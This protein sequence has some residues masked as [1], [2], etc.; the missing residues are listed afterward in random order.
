MFRG[1]P[2]SS[3]P[4]THLF[5]SPYLFTVP[6]YQRPYSWGTKEA[7]QLLDD[8][9]TAAGLD[10]AEAAWPD[11][12]LGTIL[13]L[14]PEAEG[15][16]PPPPFSGPRVFEI[17]D[18][19]QRVV[20]IS[21][22]ASVLRDLEDRN[23]SPD[24]E[25]VSLTARLN[26]MVTIEP[27]VRDI[28]SRRTR[29]L[30]RDSEQELLE[31]HILARQTRSPEYNQDEAGASFT[32]NL[33]TVHEHLW[34]E[35]AVLSHDERRR[36][37]RFLL[38]YC[39]VVVIISRDIDRAH[40]LFTVLNER[41]KPLDRKDILKAE[42]LRSIP[43]TGAP[44]AIARWEKADRDLGPE[45]E[46][47]FGHLRL[48]HGLQRMQIITGVRSLVRSYGSER[49]LSEIFTPLA[50]GF[51]NVRS[52]ANSP[53][54]ASHPELATRLIS[55]NRIGKADWVPAGI[56]AMSDFRRDPAA[57]TRLICEIERFVYLLRL[58]CY[59]AGKRQRRFA[60][61]VDAITQ[62]N[63]YALEANVWDISREEQRTIAHHLK[64][65]HRRNPSA[66][67][68]LLMRIED[69]LAGRPLMID[70]AELTIEH[71]LPLRPAATSAWRRDFPDGEIRS[72]CQASLGN[73]CLVSTQQ[74][75]RAKNVDFA[76]KLAIYRSPDAGFADFRSNEDILAAPVWT[77]D[78]IKAR[79]ARLMDVISRIWR[80]DLSPVGDRASTE[81]Q[82]DRHPVD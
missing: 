66:A 3:L 48:I 79:E 41:G 46:N 36:L 5:D 80:I 34:N 45:L 38:E 1:L 22:L 44:D 78:A 77:A 15:T 8:V 10:D 53:A 54:A 81:R 33:L 68:L 43:A 49:F 6:A 62:G 24:E 16:N 28:T 14:D 73:L 13:L 82:A 9:T 2:T 12:F 30:L 56:Q 26:A 32:S 17:V 25:S 31:T 75:E 55:L 59:G 57:A 65:I 20:T 61:I 40:R 47:F 76:A 70:P 74:N 50:D 69:E 72:I 51:D 27:D 4:V 23:G 52:F 11:Y 71:V 35:V 21:I 42:V 37:A 60:A 18:G 67:K 39:H 19:Q 29:V 64:D 63:A 58:L 7:R